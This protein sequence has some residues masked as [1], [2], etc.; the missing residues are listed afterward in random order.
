MFSVFLLYEIPALNKLVA[1]CYRLANLQLW[2]VAQIERSAHGV[3]L[4]VIE[5]LFCV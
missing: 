4:G 1:V 5:N 3:C 2:V